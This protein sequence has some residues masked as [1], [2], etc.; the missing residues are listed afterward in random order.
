MNLHYRCVRSKNS[1]YKIQGIYE[2]IYKEVAPPIDIVE[3]DENGDRKKNACASFTKGNLV[4]IMIIADDYSFHSKTFTSHAMAAVKYNDTLFAFNSW[5]ED[6]IIKK[7]RNIFNFLKNKYK[8]KH[9]YLY[10]GKSF[11]DENNYGICVG[12][13]S[14]FLLEMFI[15]IKENKLPNRIL[16]RTYNNYVYKT[17]RSRGI[18]FG[19]TINSNMN[20]PTYCKTVNRNLSVVANTRKLT[21]TKP[22]QVMSLNSKSALSTEN[23]KQYARNHKIQLN[24]KLKTTKQLYNYLRSYMKM[25]GS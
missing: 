9:L 4:G 8:C 3:F 11:Q 14:N 13:V 7:D 22:S 23:L 6:R 20:M 25:K 21:T 10:K 17:L 24:S 5:G 2:S 1:L 18:C 19:T 12:M 16:H 15:M